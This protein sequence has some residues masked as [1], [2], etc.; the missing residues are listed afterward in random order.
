MVEPERE[1]GRRDEE[2]A[3]K[4]EEDRPLAGPRAAWGGG[5]LDGLFH[6]IEYGRNTWRKQDAD[7]FVMIRGKMRENPNKIEVFVL[8]C[9]KTAARFVPSTSSE[10]PPRGGLSGEGKDVA[11]GLVDGLAHVFGFFGGRTFQTPR[12]RPPSRTR[13]PADLSRLMCSAITDLAFPRRSAVDVIV[14]LG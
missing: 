12:A 7:E 6:D 8:N 11:R 1:Q 9:G 2:E 4:D 14:A 13:R 10:T 3:E 5:G